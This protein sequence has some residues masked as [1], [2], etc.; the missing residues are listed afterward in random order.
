MCCGGRVVAM[1]EPITGLVPCLIVGGGHVADCARATLRTRVGLAVTATS[2][3]AKNGDAKPDASKA[4]SSVV[5]EIYDDVGKNIPE[6]RRRISRDDS[7]SRRSTKKRS[8]GEFVGD[9]HTSAASAAAAKAKRTRDRL[10]AKGF[11]GSRHR[12]RSHAAL[13]IFDRRT[14]T[15]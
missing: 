12:A 7:R 3:L 2:T 6:V 1:L 15:R 9:L 13:G 4:F 8:S 11:P 10:T 5:G 14:I